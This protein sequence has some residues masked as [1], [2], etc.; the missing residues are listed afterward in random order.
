MVYRGIEKRNGTLCRILKTL[1]QVTHNRL[2][3]YDFYQA[4]VQSFLL[5]IIDKQ[6]DY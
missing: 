2:S 1:N 3:N 6:F 4:D 5:M